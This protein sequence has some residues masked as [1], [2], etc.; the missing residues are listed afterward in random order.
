MRMAMISM[1]LGI[2][3]AP[4]AREPYPFACPW[5]SQ[6]MGTRAGSR[7]YAAIPIANA[8]TTR[9]AGYHLRM[10]A[11]RWFGRPDPFEQ[12]L[13]HVLED[14]RIQLVDDLLPIALGEDEPRVTE[15]AEVARDGGPGG[16]E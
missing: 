12:V 3:N 6:W 5:I 14:C 8:Q 7:P 15:H 9:T 4:V 1:M 2:R 11:S 10:L 16:G 13:H